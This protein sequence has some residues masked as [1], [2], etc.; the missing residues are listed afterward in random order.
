MSEIRD[1][2]QGFHWNPLIGVM[3]G[4]IPVGLIIAVIVL[5]IV[6]GSK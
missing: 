5:A 4:K 2:K 3:Y 6:Y 1:E